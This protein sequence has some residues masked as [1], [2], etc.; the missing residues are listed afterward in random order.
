MK[1]DLKDTTEVGSLSERFDTS[2]KPMIAVDVEKYQAYLDGSDMTD[3][4]KEVFLQS[5]WQIIVGFVELGFG[6]HPVQ[7]ARGK[8]GPSEIEF[9]ASGEDVVCSAK[10]DKD[11]ETKGLSPK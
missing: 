10:P 5:L 2:S 11:I 4:E 3:T 8:R 6:V 1:D 9:A 7:A